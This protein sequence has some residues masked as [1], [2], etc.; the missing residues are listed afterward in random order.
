MNDM[1][2]GAMVPVPTEAELIEVLR[3]S[4][5]PNASDE[6]AKLVLGYCRAAG[7]DPMQKPVHIVPMRV[8]TG[9]KKNK[10]GDEY[11]T[12]GMRDTIMPGVGLYRV[13]AARTGQYAGQDVP[14]F[15]PM[16]T[17]TY[18]AKSTKWI[19]GQ[20]HD[21]FA[22]KT[23]EYPEWCAVTI[24]R[25]VG[26]FRSSFVAVE[27]W[28]ENY[29]TAGRDS[30]APNEM[31]SRRVRGQLAKCAEAQALRKAFPE[32]G[33]APTAEEMEGRA[34][35]DVIE[36]DE[37]PTFT[38]KPARLSDKTAEQEIARG[39]VD[40]P[41][42]E[43]VAPAVP[44]KTVVAEPAVPAGAQQVATPEGDR[45]PSTNPPQGHP[46]SDRQAAPP[47]AADGSP[48]ASEGER[49]NVI[50]TANARKIDLAAKLQTLG[51]TLDPTTLTGLTKA[52]F[53]NI[54]A[55]L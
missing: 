2:H 23:I 25:L 33:A 43:P 13:Q 34:V 18:M 26:G 20:A 29:A 52:Q 38:T 48:P 17:M 7:L 22:E 41:F 35:A 32:V 4:L 24:Y 3:S 50:V 19:A 5:Y 11:A 46:P 8:K 44:A 49:M 1:T 21:S 45:G 54:K 6:S 37:A 10:N 14:E 27:F 55:V 40:T 39:M 53:K 31:W 15:G 42:V 36:Q 30:D 12:Y 51:I 47:P 9:T 16:R 28:L